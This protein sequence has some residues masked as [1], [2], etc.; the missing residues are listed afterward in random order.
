M[1]IDVKNLALKTCPYLFARY[2]L[3]YYAIQFTKD[4]EPKYVYNDKLFT[5]LNCEFDYFLKSQDTHLALLEVSPRTGKTEFLVNVVFSYLLGSEVNKKFLFIAGNRDLKRDLR[6]KI[7]RVL[8]SEFFIKV[9]GNINIVICNESIIKLSN[10]CEILF[11][12]TNSM[13]PTGMGFHYIY[14]CDYLSYSIIRSEAKRNNAFRQSEGFFT[15]T[16]DNIKI[17]QFTK[18]IVDAQRQSIN[19]FNQYVIENANEVNKKYL[20]IT[21]PYQF[22]ENTRYQLTKNNKAIIFQE[23]E[24]IVDRFNDKTK[25][26]IIGLIG[27]DRFNAEFMQNPQEA[28]GDLIKKEHFLFYDNQ[29]YHNTF[30]REVFIVCD[31]AS[32]TG[33]ANDNSVLSCWGIALNEQNEAFLYLLDLQ[34]GKWEMP[35]LVKNV[36]EFYNRNSYDLQNKGFGTDQINGF[37]QTCYIEDQSSGT[38]IIQLL[39]SQHHPERYYNIRAIPKIVGGKYERFC[40]IGGRIQGGRVKLPSADVNHHYYKNVALDITQ[41]FLKEVSTFTH[42]NSHAHDDITDC[43]IYAC[44]LVWGEGR[45]KMFRLG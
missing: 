12:T 24:Y 35:A 41:P 14:C 34:F 11:I 45:G 17:N 20:R 30:F 38:G 8:R 33:E 1:K 21:L 19:D 10:G 7:E 28:K 42:D 29:E 39:N 9:F 5:L 16:E 22:Q 3:F 32:K 25:Q 44:H 23:G 13:V 37:L 40:G 26:N 2:S 27:L 43:L 6:S 15:R 18:I 4:I 31:T 36:I